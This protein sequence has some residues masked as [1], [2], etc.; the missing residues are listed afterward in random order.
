MSSLGQPG[1]NSGAGLWQQQQQQALGA[2]KLGKA[3]AARSTGG[4]ASFE[5]AEEL[6]QPRAAS[7]S[8]VQCPG[9]LSSLSQGAALPLACAA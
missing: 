2:R 5:V 6:G 4:G 3:L 1:Y 8:C 9:L 7:A